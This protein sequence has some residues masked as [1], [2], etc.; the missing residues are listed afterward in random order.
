VGEVPDGYGQLEADVSR[1]AAT[2]AAPS[3]PVN[4]L[5]IRR[6]MFAVHDI[7]DVLPACKSTTP[8]S[9]VSWCRTRTNT[10]SV[11]RS[12]EGIIVGQAEH[13]S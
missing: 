5:G 6:M 7:E 13:L 1:A 10:G 9:S 3:T 2:S 4:A 11:I 8:N 12:P